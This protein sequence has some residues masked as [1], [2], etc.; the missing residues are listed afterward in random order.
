MILTETSTID[1]ATLP[2]DAL[3]AQLRLGTGFA[4]DGLQDSVLTSY[5]R[6]AIGS[7]E[8]Q[9]GIILLSRD[10]TWDVTEFREDMQI[11]LPLRPVSKISTFGVFEASGAE[12]IIDIDGFSL[13]SD[14]NGTILMGDPPAIPKGG[15]AEI[16]VLA[17]FA[18]WTSLPSDLSHAVLLLAAWFYENRTGT[19]GMP[20]AVR[21]LLAPYRPRRLGGAVT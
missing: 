10:F 12:T 16:E 18:D 1:D 17:G 20:T 11:T 5:L 2:V 7:V 19:G 14:I 9:T 21:A 3:S 4:E 13:R 8:A 15:H 6:A